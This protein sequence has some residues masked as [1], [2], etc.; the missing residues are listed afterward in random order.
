MV[1]LFEPDQIAGE[2]DMDKWQEYFSINE[3]KLSILI[4]GFIVF[5]GF[6]LWQFMSTGK[7]EPSIQTIILTLIGVI[8]GFNVANVLNK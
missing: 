8:A 5:S 3:Q 2:M 4:I 6:S 1:Q 7:I